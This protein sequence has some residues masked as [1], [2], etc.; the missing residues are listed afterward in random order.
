MCNEK[1]YMTNDDVNHQE[2]FNLTN[3]RDLQVGYI[4]IYAITKGYNSALKD[5]FELVL[6]YFPK[7]FIERVENASHDLGSLWFAL[8]VVVIIIAGIVFGGYYLEM[9]KK[10]R[11]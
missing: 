2:I 3:I 1:G 9:H 10:K 5:H 7:P 11:A 6:T 4:N 8:F